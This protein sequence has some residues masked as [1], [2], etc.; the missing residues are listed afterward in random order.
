MINSLLQEMNWQ[1]NIG[2]NSNN[3]DY[4]PPENRANN[5]WWVQ[6]IWWGNTA[7]QF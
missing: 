7:N 4:I 2:N 3:P 1:S 6:V 5:A